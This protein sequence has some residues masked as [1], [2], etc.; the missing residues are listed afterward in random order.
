VYDHQLYL[1]TLSEFTRVLL[2]PYDAQSMLDQLANRVTEVL[3]L[4]GSGVSLADG[5]RLVF[6]AGVGGPVVELE[7]IQDE[8]QVG[9]CVTAFQTAQIVRVDDLGGE[10]ERW[11]E[12]CRTAEA[13]GITSVASI[14]MRLGE[15]TVGAFNLYA[16]ASRAWDEEDM[17][18]AVVMSDMAT[19][20]LINAST[21]RQQVELAEQLEHALESRVIV[22]QAK[23][24]LA[25]KHAITPEAAFERLRHHARSRGAT[26]RSVAQAIVHLGMDLD[27]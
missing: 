1:R 17:A 19:A 3:G 16:G 4:L 13:L 5:E 18:A 15:R 9:P 11:P 24:M 21:H 25:A 8:T 2:T 26:V 7:K 10:A 12:Y 14:P 6:E 22:E 23:G 27:G 20:Y